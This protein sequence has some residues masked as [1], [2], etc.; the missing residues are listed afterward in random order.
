MD[1]SRR[2]RGSKAH[3]L[4]TA[5]GLPLRVLVGPADQHDLALFQGLMEGV[6]LKGKRGAQDGAWGGV[7]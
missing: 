5:R 3:A 6:R 2:R 7:G 4:A 1:G